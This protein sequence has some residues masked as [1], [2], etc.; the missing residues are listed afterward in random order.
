MMK[1]SL[2]Q[3]AEVQPQLPPVQILRTEL[4]HKENAGFSNASYVHYCSFLQFLREIAHNI[5]L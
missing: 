3:K 4:S 1:Y 2:E 5:V